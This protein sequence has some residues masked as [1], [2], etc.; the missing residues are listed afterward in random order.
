MS[1]NTMFSSDWKK[2][3]AFEGIKLTAKALY[4]RRGEYKVTDSEIEI[5]YHKLKEMREL[6]IL[7]EVSERKVYESV[8]FM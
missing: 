2:W 6:G 7:D 4:G 5:I 3:V 1:S 8:L